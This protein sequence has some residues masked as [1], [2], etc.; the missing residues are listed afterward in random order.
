V[1]GIAPLGR[2]RLSGQHRPCRR[3]GAGAAHSD[4]D[5]EHDQ[6]GGAV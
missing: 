2:R 4:V 3:P 6:A 5:A 1:A